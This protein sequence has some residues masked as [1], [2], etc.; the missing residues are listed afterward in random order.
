MDIFTTLES[1]VRSYCRSFPT[2]FVKSLG[3][4][5]IDE[6][7]NRYIDF[8]AGAGALNY[9]HNNPLFKNVLIDYLQ[10]DG[11]TQSLDL[12]TAAKRTFLERFN[13]L[14]L[15]PRGFNYKIMFHYCPLKKIETAV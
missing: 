5:L 3:H 11:I 9:G 14:I 12:F 13:E 7:G 2:V 1:E 6:D 8:L 4:E 15:K 10:S